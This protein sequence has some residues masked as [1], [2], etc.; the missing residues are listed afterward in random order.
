VKFNTK[1]LL[2]AVSSFGEGL[3]QTLLTALAE[4]AFKAIVLKLCVDGW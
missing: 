2:I 3:R 4:A 1:V